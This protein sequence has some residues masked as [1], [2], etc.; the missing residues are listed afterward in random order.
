MGE[1]ARDAVGRTGIRESD[2]QI[3]EDPVDE[4]GRSL[5]NPITDIYTDVHVDDSKA[6]E[7]K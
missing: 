7:S 4:R 6:C 3:F 5:P 1:R 2:N